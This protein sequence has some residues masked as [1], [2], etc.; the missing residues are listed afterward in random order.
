MK[1]RAPNFK[2][3]NVLVCPSS[4]GIHNYLDR[5]NWT[6]EIVEQIKRYT[7]R[8]IKIR[9]KHYGLV[10]RCIKSFLEFNSENQIIPE[11]L[12]LQLWDITTMRSMVF[13]FG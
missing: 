8:P 13:H 6:Q 9:E 11:A 1:V 3:K 5:P 12:E 10:D 2:G 7:D 4:A